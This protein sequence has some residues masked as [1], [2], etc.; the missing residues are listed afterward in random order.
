[1]FVR[2][3]V[4]KPL[5]PK[6]RDVHGFAPR[7]AVGALL[8]TVCSL[9]AQ[10]VLY[11][12]PSSSGFD[13]PVLIGDV[14]ND[15]TPDL[16]MIRWFDPW[17]DVY[18]GTT[19]A[20]LQQVAPAPSYLGLF[21][22]R[23][24]GDMDG[25][26][27]ADYLYITSTGGPTTSMSHVQV[28][29]SAT[30]VVLYTSPG[31]LGQWDSRQLLDCLGDIN[32]DGKVEILVGDPDHA[33]RAGKVEVID[34]AT[35][36]V[37]RT[38]VGAFPSE[39]RCQVHVIGDADRDGYEDYVVR[40]G[41][42]VLRGYSGLTGQQLF[43]LSAGGTSFGKYIEKV[44]DFNSDGFAD[45]AV[46]DEGNYPFATYQQAFVFG[47]PSGTQLWNRIF[48]YSQPPPPPDL[49]MLSGEIGDLDGDGYGDLAMS[50]RVVSGRNHAVIRQGT[51]GILG[52][53]GDVDGDGIRDLI[54][55]VYS[56]GSWTNYL[57]SGAPPGVSTIGTPCADVTGATPAIG[58]TI[59]ARLGQ[60]MDV[61]LSNANPALLAAVLA[62][63]H[64]NQQWNGIPL[65]FDLGFVGMPG[66]QWR[67]A[68]DVALVLPTA[69]ANGT[70]HHAT[71]ALAVPANSQLLGLDVFA[72]WLTLEPSGTGLTGATTRTARATVVP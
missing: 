63:G 11:T 55:A 26:G 18:S 20:F 46:W 14:D 49:G 42:G 34:G 58:I 68:A 21:D 33:L 67:V 36:G 22:H 4:A 6:S 35:G 17:F 16:V 27:R 31:V 53:P 10:T 71:Y 70:R 15:G 2:S 56:A 64:S 40:S 39:F 62:L 60:T 69:G 19:G 48:V 43:V 54:S 44:G 5:R 29:S 13:Y 30:G 23:P 1:M 65:P 61:N 38:H 9:Q 25:D 12:L 57:I 59:G 32:A 28:R 24:C 41:G 66:C 45:F 51:W 3:P 72:Q 7:V 50:Y 37:L 8:V 47:G 52:S